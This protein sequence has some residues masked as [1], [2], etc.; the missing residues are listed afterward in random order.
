MIVTVLSELELLLLDVR[1]GRELIRGMTCDS[2]VVSRLYML[3]MEFRLPVRT[4]RFCRE[5]A[6]TGTRRKTSLLLAGRMGGSGRE[7]DRGG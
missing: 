7:N 4:A 2:P 1:E 6:G 5:R 3:D